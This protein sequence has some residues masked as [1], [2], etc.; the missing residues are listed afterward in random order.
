ML[1]LLHRY[2]LI[3]AR[4]WSTAIK[5]FIIILV[6]VIILVVNIFECL[7]IIQGL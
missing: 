3:K 7:L 2:F 5:V 6:V 1:V 4:G